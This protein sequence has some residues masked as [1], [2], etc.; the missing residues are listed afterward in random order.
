[1]RISFELTKQYEIFIDKEDVDNC[2]GGDIKVAISENMGKA[3]ETDSY[4]IEIL[5]TD[6]SAEDEAYEERLDDE[7]KRE[8]D[9]QESLYLRDLI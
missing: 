6:L 4:D 1:M 5:D 7:Y 9:L 3:E 2:Y 8:E